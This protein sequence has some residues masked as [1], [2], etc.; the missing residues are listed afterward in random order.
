M[1][2][3]LVHSATVHRVTTLT[4]RMPERLNGWTVPMMAA[5]RAALAQ[6][7]ADDGTAAIILTGADPY[8]SAGV[9]LG[10][11]IQLAHP[12]TL[13]DQILSHN[14]GLFDSFIDVSKPILAAVNGP[15]IGAAVTSATLCDAIVASDR[16]TFST[17]FARLAV[18]PEGCSSVQFERMMGAQGAARMLG[19]QG[20]V[21]TGAEAAEVG[22]A[23]R[24]VPHEQLLAAAQEAAEAWVFAGKARSFRCGATA[25]KLRE[26]NARESRDLASAFLGAPFLR[27][28]FHFLRSKRKWSAAAVFLAMWGTRPLWSRLLDVPAGR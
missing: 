25:E 1:E 8:Y 12:Q 5:L 24:V 16:A 21:P 22:L 13:Y 28:Q 7:D 17:P 2:D 18:P 4:M 3:A 11:T 19:P 9:H 6:A 26:I 14:Q 23:D 15:A 10:S 27:S 20:W